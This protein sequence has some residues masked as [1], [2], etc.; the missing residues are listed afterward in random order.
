[1]VAARKHT[2][3][4]KVKSTEVDF[5]FG[6]SSIWLIYTGM[7]CCFSQTV[8]QHNFIKCR[9]M[10]VYLQTTVSETSAKNMINTKGNKYTGQYTLMRQ[11][12]KNSVVCQSQW[13]EKGYW[14]LHSAFQPNLCCH[15]CII[16]LLLK[17]TVK[18]FCN[19]SLHWEKYRQHPHPHPRGKNMI[20]FTQK[21]TWTLKFNQQ[22]F[23]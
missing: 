15:F 1:M 13:K 16:F 19:I 3:R 2:H 5:F 9:Y 14:F 18:I 23:F 8:V 10:I 6:H 20:D 17:C 7:K 4:V 22:D 21:Y 11:D 12:I